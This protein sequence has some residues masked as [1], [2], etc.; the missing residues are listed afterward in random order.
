MKHKK[1]FVFGDYSQAEARIVAWRGPVPLLKQWF[2]DGKDVHLET[3]RLIG[4]EVHRSKLQLPDNLFIR[5]L[6]GDYTRDDPERD[7]SKTTVYGNN[8]GQGVA[9]F[10]LEVGMPE[11]YARLLQTIYHQQFPE[12]R[13]NYQ[14]GIQNQLRKDRTLRTPFGGRIIFYGRL[15]DD[16]F[17]S[18]YSW[19]PSNIVGALTTRWFN[20][21]SNCFN[22]Q[23]EFKTTVSPKWI[24]ARGLDIRFQVHDS[25]G[26]VCPDDRESIEYA[27][28][29][30]KREG[31]QPV[32]ING[33]ELIIPVDFKVGYRWGELKDWG[34]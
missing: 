12:I 6:P 5:K 25:L 1:V 19:Y 7:K 31:E 34:K 10:A 9:R 17:R 2:K 8:Y 29:I 22:K 18:A 33:E 13:T 26:I 16:T 23:K 4:T 32:V 20:S 15:D 14:A 3:A 28:K 11:M 24:K 21:V 27:I 30:M